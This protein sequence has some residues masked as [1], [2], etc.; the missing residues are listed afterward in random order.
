MKLKLTI[1]VNGIFH[2]KEANAEL[3]VTQVQTFDLY[4]TSQV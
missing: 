1:L 4:I 3:N 2:T